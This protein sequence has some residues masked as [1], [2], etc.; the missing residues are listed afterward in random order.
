MDTVSSLFS[1]SKKGEQHQLVKELH[2]IGHSAR[3]Q[4][5]TI[6]AIMVGSVELSV[7]LTN[8]INMYLD[9]EHED[10]IR[11]LS[12]TDAKSDLGGYARETLSTLSCNLPLIYLLVPCCNLGLNPPFKGVYRESTSLPSPQITELDAIQVP[13]PVTTTPAD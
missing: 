4:A 12:S 7:A 6:L 11:R 5:N 8:M 3:E 2:K 9:S 13:L 1:K 10:T